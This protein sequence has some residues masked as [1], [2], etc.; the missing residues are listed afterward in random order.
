MGVTGVIITGA[1]SGVGEA[2]AIR[3]ARRKPRRLL[4]SGRNPVRLM[5]VATECEHL[6]AEVQWLAGDLASREYLRDILKLARSL[7]EIEG[8]VN[9][10]GIGR[11][12]PAVSVTDQMWDEVIAVNLSALFFLCRGIGAL[13]RKQKSTSTIVNVSSE[14]DIVGYENATAYCASKGGVLAMTR[15]L[16]TEYRMFGIRTCILSPGRI[17]TR[18]HGKKPGMRPGALTAGEV[19]EVIEFLITCSPNI[20]IREVRIDG[21]GMIKTD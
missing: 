9:A 3:L 16:E 18:F 12:G 5:A 19:A 7:G 4:L 6:G 15:A 17:D 13:L 11:F 14:A 2:T 21:M 20:R 8:L 1:S 10:A